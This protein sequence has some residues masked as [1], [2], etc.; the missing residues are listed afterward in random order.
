MTN[1]QK[2]I[3]KRYVS[4]VPVEQIPRRY[5]KRLCEVQTTISLFQKKIQKIHQ[6]NRRF[7]NKWIKL[8]HSKLQIIEYYYTKFRFS[9]LTLDDM[10]RYL[11]EKVGGAWNISESTISWALRTKINM[12]YKKINK[13][14]L[15]TVSNLNKQK[16]IEAAAI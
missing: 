6:N 9:A 8:D 13:V 1:G 12:T 10:K 4:G 15:T 3:V 11:I 5:N 14:H 16:L 2:L 7:L